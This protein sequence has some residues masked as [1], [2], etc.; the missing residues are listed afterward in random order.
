M[1]LYG[2]IPAVIVL[3]YLIITS[4]YDFKYRKIPFPLMICG[5]AITILGIVLSILYTIDTGRPYI[6]IMC[7]AAIGLYLILTYANAQAIKE[8][9]NVI[10]GGGDLVVLMAVSSITPFVLGSI[11][12]LVILPIGAFLVSTLVRLIPRINEKYTKRGIPY[13][14]Y[15]GLI[16]IILGLIPFILGITY[17]PFS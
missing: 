11:P 8:N 9:M 7:I 4:I 12:A 16:W 10:I 17:N 5:Y 3:V 1:I 15:M 14:P 2:I 6:I 13:I